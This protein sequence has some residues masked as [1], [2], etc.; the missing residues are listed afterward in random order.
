MISQLLFSTSVLQAF[1]NFF[2]SSHIHPQNRTLPCDISENGSFTLFDCRARRIKTVPLPINYSASIVELLL[3]ENYI[4]TISAKSFQDWQNLTKIVLN[5]NLNPNKQDTDICKRGLDIGKDT[6][7]TLRNLKELYIDQN[8]LCKMPTGLPRSL[9]VLSLQNNNIF[10]ISKDDLSKLD[11]LKKLYLGHNCYYGNKCDGVFEIEVGAFADLSQ[12]TM[13]SLSFN[14][15]TKVPPMLPSS[16]KELYLSNNR[17]KVVSREDFKNLVN[18]EILHLSSN[19][20]RCFNAA[21]P[22]EPCIGQSSIEIDLHAFEKLKNLLELNLASTSLKSIPG[23]WF[24]NTT[25][26]KSLNLELNYLVKE[27]ATAEFL[28]NLPSL[29]FLDLS[30]NYETRSYPR[31]INISDNF[32]KLVSLKHLCIEGYVFKDITSFNLAPLTKLKNLHI[33]N[34]AVN[35]VRQVDFKVFEQIPNLRVIDLSENKISPFSENNNQSKHL[36]S[37]SKPEHSSTEDEIGG[38]FDVTS[39][40]TRGMFSTYGPPGKTPYCSNGK[41]LDLSLNSIFFIDPEEFRPFGDVSCLNLSANGIGQNLNGTE[42]IYLKSL[43]YLDLSFNKLDFASI[44]A[45]QEIPQLEVLDVSYNKHYFV[46]EGVTHHLK[47]IENLHNLQI[48]N[49]SW[50]EISTLTEA[51]INSHSLKELR[52]AGNRLD[53]LWKLGDTRYLNIFSNLNNLTVLDISSNRLENIYDDMLLTLPQSLTELYLNDNW[54]DYFEWKSLKYFKH[55]KLLDLSYNRITMIM[56]NLST[57]T[58]SLQTLILHKNMISS[59]PAEFLKQASN[60]TD[61]DL[62][63][64]NLQNINKSIFLSG[65]ENFLKVLNLK[66]NP[67]DCTCDI[68]DFIMWINENNVAIPRLATDV[69]CA[70]PIDKKGSGIIY[71]DWKACNMDDTS[72]LLFVLSFFVV[73][74][75]TALPIMKHLFYWDMWYIYYVF[76][77]WV[78]RE[79]VTTSQTLYDAYVSYD[80]KDAAV[81]DWVF[82]E[83]CYHLEDTGDKDILLCLEE[84]DWELGKAV[85]DNIVQSINESKKTLFILTKSF[86]TS[87]RFKTAFYLALQKLMDENMDVIIIV[88]LEPVLLN[89]QYF[90]LRKKICKSSIL[91]WPKN[92]HAEDFF[93][94]QM[95]NVLLTDNSSRYNHLYTDNI[96]L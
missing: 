93:W 62:S 54:L 92:P 4:D 60:L 31:S 23:K 21:Y 39:Q 30:Y 64:N 91:E 42:F 28:F 71:F 48:L 58:Y 47:F 55:L 8:Y 35:F 89:S 79:K 38:N 3:S 7:S 57:Y 61:L 1:S 33:I 20:P 27:I 46:V 5:F 83:L 17:I 36:E 44:N 40:V 65:N 15:L 18:L 9:Q 2:G 74:P 84:R 86:V 59:L 72:M 24:E 51:Q 63:H 81:S 25:Q 56:S 75:L 66:E 78:K 10:S 50:N 49:L 87:G 43:I 29:E 80:T 6:F 26:L 82:N 70:T 37:Y 90:R 12:L 96:I 69:L 16:L 95:R 68:T 34:L 41:T 94:Q 85:I 67:F 14:N 52:F 73:I 45:F 77:A 11:L 32:S 22:C 19:C 88:L 53:V 76:L 13:L